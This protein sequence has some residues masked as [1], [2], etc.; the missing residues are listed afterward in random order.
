[1]E[2]LEQNPLETRANK[3]KVKRFRVTTAEVKAIE[4]KAAK[5]GLSFSEYCRRAALD[6]PIVELIPPD[7]RRQISTAGNN[8]NQLTRLA[9]AGKLGGASVETLNELLTRLLETLK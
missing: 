6:K 7:L 8:L 2:E 3:E 1:M 5:A 4:K 9:N